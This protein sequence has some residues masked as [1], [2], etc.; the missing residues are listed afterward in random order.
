MFNR[1]FAVAL[2]RLAQSYPIITMTGLLRQAGIR[3]TMII[4]IQK[5]R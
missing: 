3:S 1:V 4:K 2:K 5:A